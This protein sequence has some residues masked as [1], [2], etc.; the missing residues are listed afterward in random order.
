MADVDTRPAPSRQSNSMGHWI[1]IVLLGPFVGTLAIVLLPFVID[2]PAGGLSE[3]G[4]MLGVLFTFGYIFGIVPS[5]LSA[6]VYSRAAPRLTTFWSRLIGCI[7]IGALCGGLGVIVP[8]WILARSFVIDPNFMLMAALAGAF[9]LPLT[10][11]PFR[12][13]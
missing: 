9:A 5:S 1:V 6:L 3:M 10:A 8:I 4:P 2:P 11:L 7:M 13:R 12:P